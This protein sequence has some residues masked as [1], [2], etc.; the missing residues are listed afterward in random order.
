ML[1]RAAIAL[2]RQSRLPEGFSLISVLTSADRLPEDVR[3]LAVVVAEAKFRNVQGHIFARNLVENDD[4]AALE[5]APEAFNRLRVD[6]AD[7]VIIQDIFALLM[8]DGRVREQA[9]DTAI[10]F[11]AIRA[12]QA[13]LAGNCFT[14]EL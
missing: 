13:D 4:N 12:D 2:R 3:V 11:P 6:R 9:A 7:H 1:G 10:A 14:D 5:D 8:I